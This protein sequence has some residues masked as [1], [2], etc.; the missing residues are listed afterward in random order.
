M[1]MPPRKAPNV[2]DRPIAPVPHAAASATE[3][4]HCRE[5]F[6]VTRA[7]DHAKQGP[8]HETSEQYRDDEGNGRLQEGK[9]HGR[10]QGFAGGESGRHDEEEVAATSWKIR[11]AVAVSPTGQFC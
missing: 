7:R 6:F 5:D 4:C 1:I 9:A 2:N 11:M 3:K 10:C 8:D